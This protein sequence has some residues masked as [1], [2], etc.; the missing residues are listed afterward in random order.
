VLVGWWD[1]NGVEVQAIAT[2]ALVLITMFYAW[3]TARTRKD[4]ADEWERRRRELA[5]VQVAAEGQ[6]RRALINDALFELRSNLQLGDM[7]HV[8]YAWLPFPLEAVEA[9]SR[10]LPPGHGVHQRLSE[11]RTS[12]LRYN[13]AAAYSNNQVP[14]GNGAMD[15]FLGGEVG[16]LKDLLAEVISLVEGLLASLDSVQA[17]GISWERYG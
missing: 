17:S 4:Q 15:P 10:A 16:K 6:R 2:V 11:V 7:A 14:F 12:L 1:R 8:S 3:Q 5:D 13:A 9:L